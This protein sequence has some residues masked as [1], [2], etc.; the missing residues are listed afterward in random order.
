MAAVVWRELRDEFWSPN[1]CEAVIGVV[2][3]QAGTPRVDEKHL[4]ADIRHFVNLYVT[5]HVSRAWQV[6]RV[7]PAGRLELGGDGWHVSEL[8]HINCGADRQ[9]AAAHG[10]PHR[11]VER[12]E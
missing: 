8:P 4:V 12:A 9:S 1:G 11:L 10:Q 2:P 7:M 5:G 6:A 3:R